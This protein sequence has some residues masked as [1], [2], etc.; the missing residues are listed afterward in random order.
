VE[1]AI[2][3][4]K[5]ETSRIADGAAPALGERVPRAGRVSIDL[6]RTSL[7]QHLLPLNNFRASVLMIRFS[8]GF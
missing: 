3:K 6:Q 2:K 4:M 7:S 8:R 1:A 5:I